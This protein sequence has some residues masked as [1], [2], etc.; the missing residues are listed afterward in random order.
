MNKC[1]LKLWLLGFRLRGKR[2]LNVPDCLRDIRVCPTIVFNHDWEGQYDGVV[3]LVIVYSGIAAAHWN[4]PQP[5]AILPGGIGLERFVTVAKARK[6]AF[7]SSVGR[8][9]TLHPGK[10]TFVRQSP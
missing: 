7:V 6:W 9:S 10:I 1:Q 3:D 4:G 8:L 2:D 5:V